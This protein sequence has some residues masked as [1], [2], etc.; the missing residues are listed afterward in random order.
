MSFGPRVYTGVYIGAQYFPQTSLPDDR[1]AQIASNQVTLRSDTLCSRE[2]GRQSDVIDFTPPSLT[3]PPPVPGGVT[4]ELLVSASLRD[5]DYG[6]GSVINRMSCVAWC[7]LGSVGHGAQYGVQGVQ[8]GPYGVTY[9]STEPG[10]LSDALINWQLPSAKRTPF[11]TSG[12]AS[13]C[14][15]LDRDGHVSGWFLGDHYGYDQFAH[16]QGTFGSYAGRLNKGTADKDDDQWAFHTNF[17]YNNTWY[18]GGQSPP[19]EYDRTYRIGI[20]WGGPTNAFEYWVDGNLVRAGTV[21]LPWGSAGLGWGS[22]TNLAL[23]D[24]HERGVHSYG[25]LAGARFS[26]LHLWKGYIA[27]GDSTAACPQHAILGTPSITTSRSGNATVWVHTVNEPASGNVRAIVGS[28]AYAYGRY[29]DSTPDVG[30]ALTE[31]SMPFRVNSP[32]LCSSR[33]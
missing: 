24:N 17:W 14:I 12:T 26:D 28:A 23:G 8:N 10:G 27:Q 22:A 16:G 20:A 11:R 21:P 6:G 33:T 32:T 15:T 13:M 25:T 29:L 18:P 19:L 31:G 30:D 2:L 4:P 9:L 7:W 5:G 3:S 1:C